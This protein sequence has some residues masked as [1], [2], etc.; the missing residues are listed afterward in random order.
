MED[1]NLYMITEILLYYVQGLYGTRSSAAL[2]VKSSGHVSFY[3]LYL[4]GHMWKEHVI[5]FHIRKL[6]WI[7]AI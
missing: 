7:E 3:E 1:W 6:K 4:D 2:T 5:D